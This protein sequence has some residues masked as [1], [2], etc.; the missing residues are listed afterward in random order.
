MKKALTIAALV[1]LLATSVAHA[2]NCYPPQ[3]DPC[4]RQKALELANAGD[5][6][7]WRLRAETMRRGGTMEAAGT[8]RSKRDFQSLLHDAERACGRRR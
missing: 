6:R 8:L 5:K 4:V 3:C 1:A 2:Q 7:Y